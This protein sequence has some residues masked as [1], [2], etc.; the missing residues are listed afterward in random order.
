MR[1]KV[2]PSLVVLAVLGIQVSLAE[3]QVINGNG[4]TVVAAGAT[5]S[6]YTATVTLETSCSFTVKLKVFKNGVQKFFSST[7]VPNPGT[8]TYA[9][10]KYVS[11]TTWPPAAGDS[12]DYEGQ[13]WIGGVLQSTHHWYVTVSGGT[14]FLE[15]AR[16]FR[17]WERFLIKEEETV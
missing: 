16:G 1:L 10:S 4:P 3:A 13:L 12:L 17:P 14:T 11:M 5:S 15:P 2:L 9:F 7:Y 8:T 6:T